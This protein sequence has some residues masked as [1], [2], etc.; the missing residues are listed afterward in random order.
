ME[1][2]PRGKSSKQIEEKYHADGKDRLTP[3]KLFDDFRKS[4]LEFGWMYSYKAF[5]R[6][7]NE[8]G[9][10]SIDPSV[11]IEPTIQFVE[12]EKNDNSRSWGTSVLELLGGERAFEFLVQ[13]IKKEKEQGKRYIHT[14]F[15]AL[16]AIHKI[17]T[18]DNDKKKQDELDKLLED[19]WDDNNKEDYLAQAGATILLALS[20]SSNQETKEKCVANIKDMLS[21]KRFKE[22]WPALRALRAL[23][24]FP[25]PGLVDEIISIIKHSDYYDHKHAAILA[26]G[27]YKNELEA[28]RTLGLIVRNNPDS[29]LRL[30]AIRSLAKLNDR[31]SHEDLVFALHDDNA[32]VRVQAAYAL[33]SLL[34]NEAILTI[35]QNALRK[36][37]GKVWQDRFIEALRIID[38]PDRILSTEALGKEVD[39]DDR[40]RAELAEKMILELGGWAAVHRISQRRNTLKTL[41]NLL[42]QSEQA[43]KDTFEDTIKQ[44]R[45]NFFFAMGVN[46]VIVTVGL[47]L[48]GIAIMQLL[49]QPQKLETWIVP[50]G[51]GLFG[52]IVTMF[53]NN[54]RQN[55]RED[56]T[57]LMN[58]NV[59]FLGFLRQLNEVDATFKHAYI[60]SR[61][62]GMEDMKKTRDAIEATVSRTLEMTERHLRKP[63]YTLPLRRR[64]DRMTDNVTDKVNEIVDK[65]DEN[66][67]A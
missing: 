60:E 48:V 61:F 21:T 7:K 37:I 9:T 52:I 55:A 1:G 49:Q 10:D 50:G 34:G 12:N 17:A 62:F 16:K 13:M 26:L 53:F 32:E 18:L 36:D 11:F 29:S 35:V 20:K 15:F 30:Q 28:I 27:G 3:E 39:G 65:V 25:L 33:K 63:I 58:V 42:A 14:R 57:T 45:Q 2:K 5:E 56:L 19:M 8:L 46:I 41:D 67:H 54:P 6:F 64:G 4:K 43:V 31:D 51:A 59:I 40:A 44:A 66:D 24:E 38:D 47:F 22:Y 23:R